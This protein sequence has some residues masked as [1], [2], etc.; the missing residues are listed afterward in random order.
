MKS[1]I[2]KIYGNR[3][4]VRVCG[5]CRDGERLL[6]VNHK[7]GPQTDFWAPPGGG[8]EFGDSIVETLKKEFLEE[9][10][11]T[12]EVGSFAFGCEYLAPPLHAVELFFEVT[13]IDG[14]LKSGYDPELQ[15]I[16]D[17]AYLSPAEIL[18]KPALQLHGIFRHYTQA[19]QLRNLKGFYSI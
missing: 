2:A 15:I 9:T 10:N 1:E 12:I 16:Q 18:S 6:L 17:T 8:V 7:G 11:L 19:G 3:L 4:R 13:V 5:L 14:D